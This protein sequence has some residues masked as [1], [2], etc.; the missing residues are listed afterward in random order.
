MSRV[1]TLPPMRLRISAA[2]TVLALTLVGCSSS[3]EDEAPATDAPAATEAAPAAEPVD[4]TAELLAANPDAPWA[5]NV[6][7]VTEVEPGRVDLE[8]TIVDPRGDNDSPEAQSAIAA[9]QA[10]V[11]LL[12]DAATY[13]RVYEA[14]G[15]SFVLYSVDQLPMDLPSNECV[16]A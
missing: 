10:T 15:T 8:T 16:E 13:V 11:A 7:A 3:G 6:T 14:D 5:A 12:G 2:S 4:R 9:C 1:G